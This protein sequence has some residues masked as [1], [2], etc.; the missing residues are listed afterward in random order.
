METIS[1]KNYPSGETWALWQMSNIL[2]KYQF[3]KKCIR[4]DIHI[5]QS[6]IIVKLSLNTLYY[7]Y[8]SYYT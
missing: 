5:L 6:Q 3:S 7:T 1:L 4:S 8:I 2:F